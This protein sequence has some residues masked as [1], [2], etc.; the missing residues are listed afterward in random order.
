MGRPDSDDTFKMS[1]FGK[2]KFP[3][4]LKYSDKNLIIENSVETNW[5]VSSETKKLISDL[6]YKN[7]I[8]RHHIPIKELSSLANQAAH[9]SLKH[10]MSLLI[11]LVMKKYN[12]DHW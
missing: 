3:Y 8:L 7:I 5:S 4:S 1:N 9:K 6:K 12:M 11:K 2:K 10:L